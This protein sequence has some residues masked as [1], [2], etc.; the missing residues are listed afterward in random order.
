MAKMKKKREPGKAQDS[1]L[2][3]IL[4]F[5]IIVVLF[6]LIG[7]YYFLSFSPIRMPKE[8]IASL[9]VALA[10]LPPP[11]EWIPQ[12]QK[13]SRL[14]VAASS[15]AAVDQLSLTSDSDPSFAKN[16]ADAEISSATSESSGLENT[17]EM[18]P[19]SV[20]VGEPQKI[21][22]QAFGLSKPEKEVPL[23]TLPAETS[24]P[25]PAPAIPIE[26]AV[27]V[28]G[29]YVLQ[30]DVEKARS[31]LASLGLTAKCEVIKLPTPMFR[32]YLGPFSN[33]LETQ[34]MMDLARKMG[35]Q[36]FIHKEKA[37]NL[38]IVGS[39][40]L[41]SSVVAWENMYHDAGLS[42]KVRQESLLIPHTQLFLDGAQ[43]NDNPEAVLARVRAAG[44]TEANLKKNPYLK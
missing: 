30:T 12:D 14:P 7:F 43:L 20:P 19:D 15:L 8:P 37:G 31:Q 32:V 25:A 39:F 27:V 33:R 9:P 6:A 36:P 34:K 35:D 22:P 17:P 1:L 11:S 2:E 18:A 38:V 10:L 41:E 16:A 42:P 29:N 28:V 44:F 24:Q 23:A 21:E 13:D 4:R 40:Y 3:T 5:E 26:E